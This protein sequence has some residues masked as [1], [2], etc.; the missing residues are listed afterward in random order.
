MDKKG[1][2]RVI[3]LSVIVLGIIITPIIYYG[4]VN[5]AIYEVETTLSFGSNSPLTA[6]GKDLDRNVNRISYQEVSQVSITKKD[7]VAHAQLLK[8]I[9][10][11]D[12][13]MHGDDTSTGLSVV[14]LEFS[15]TLTA[16]NGKTFNFSFK[17]RE[18]KAQREVTITTELNENELQR[19]QG[20]FSI[21]IY[22]S[23]KI[24][25]PIVA[26][27]I[28]DITLNP[29]SRNFTVEI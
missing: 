23:I 24:T 2:M 26:L 29:I 15:F 9:F 1:L 22:I 8:D 5:A 20:E 25:P 16:P 14:E 4:S 28:I 12:V 19:M 27:P 11:K 3:I 6:D 21:T 18:L 17:P 7:I 10:G 13:Q